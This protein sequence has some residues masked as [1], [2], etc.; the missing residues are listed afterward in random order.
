MTESDEQPTAESAIPVPPQPAELSE[1]WP[2]TRQLDPR[3]V[4]LHR[5]GS[6]IFT[7]VVSIGSLIPLVIL[8]VASDISDDVGVVLVL[9]WLVVTL[10][11]SWLTYAWPPLHYQ[12]VS[13]T[14]D[15]EGIEIR[16]GVWWRQVTNVPRSRVQHIDVSQGPLERR[17]GLGRLVLF[18]A[19]TSHSRVE[20]DGLSHEMAFWLRNHLLPKGSDDAV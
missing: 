7:A 10:G 4:A 20:L 19:G 15:D 11:L 1:S 13:Y 6:A 18:T 3:S 14:L 17:Y 12:H 2:L 16:S 9:A 8:L 5:V